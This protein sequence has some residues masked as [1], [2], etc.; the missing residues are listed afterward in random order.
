MN[1]TWRA[2]AYGGKLRMAKLPLK[3]KLTIKFSRLQSQHLKFV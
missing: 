1:K 3:H 2:I